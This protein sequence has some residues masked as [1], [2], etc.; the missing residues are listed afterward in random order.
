MGLIIAWLV[1][2]FTF[3]PEPIRKVAAWATVVVAVLGLMW[4]AKAAYDA[5]V[6]DDYEDERAIESIEARDQAAEQRATDTIRN[7]IA[8][9]EARDA[10]NSV[11]ASD[12]RHRLACLRQHRLGR[13]PVSCRRYRGDG[14]QAG[15]E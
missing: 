3:L 10:I 6:I 4:A 11:P 12:A 15:S 8:E 13:D 9:K 14:T 1:G 5:S 7:T 2:K